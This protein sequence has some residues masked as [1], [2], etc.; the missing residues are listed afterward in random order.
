MVVK[1]FLNADKLILLHLRGP[2]FSFKCR[3]VTLILFSFKLLKVIQLRPPQW[4]DNGKFI[5]ILYTK[6]V[7]SNWR[8]NW[9]EIWLNSS[10]NLQYVVQMALFNMEWIIA[11][12]NSSKLFSSIVNKFLLINARFEGFWLAW[13]TLVYTGTIARQHCFDVQIIFLITII[14]GN[15]VYVSVMTV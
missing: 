9:P 11:H 6:K 1:V 5:A 3:E 2:T 14:H 8:K 13:L 4:D 7:F 12:I 10:V 15:D